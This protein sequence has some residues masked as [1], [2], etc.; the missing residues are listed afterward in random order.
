[1]KKIRELI[2]RKNLLKII[3]ILFMLLFIV[4]IS[5]FQLQNDTFYDIVLGGKYINGDFSKIDTYSIHEGL[6]Y[7]T[8]HFMVCIISFIVYS[9]TSFTGLHVLEIF[10]TCIIATLFYIANRQFVKSKWLSYFWVY[11]EI[12]IMSPFISLRAQM[13]SYILFLLEIIFIEKFLNTSKKKYAIFLTLIPMF[14]A[15]FHSGV[16]YLYYI[17][18]LLYMFNYS[19][20][21]ILRIKSDKRIDFKKLKTF[22]IIIGVSILLSL[23]NPYGIKGLTYG[24]KTINNSFINSYIQEFQPSSINNTL[25]LYVVI[26]IAFILFCVIMSKRDIKLNSILIFVGTTFMFLK[27]L[28]HASI[29]MIFSVMMLSYIE[30]IY[31][32]FKNW[33]YKDIKN[34]DVDIIKKT[35]FL[36]ISM[37]YIVYIST[38]MTYIETDYLNGYPINAVKYI[39]ENIGQDARIYNEYEWGSYLMFNDIKVFI[40]S[41]C[42]LYTEEY[43]KNTRVGMDYMETYDF[44]QDYNDT[45]EKYNIEYFLLK[46]DSLLEKILLLDVKYT[47]I[48]E[49]DTACII[50]VNK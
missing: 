33:L 5:P 48:Y 13:Y 39:K 8:H 50:K 27:S 34:K 41:R 31:N 11:I 35:I 6:V 3:L 40:D 17:I 29:F 25:V 44:K 23:I 30:D 47:K 22:L 15:N 7:Q 19:N 4:V 2:N 37:A 24:L 42:D 36:F 20:I 1:M 21:N 38:R 43:N 28:R 26:Y 49:D 18:I 10:L 9:Y 32:V 46:K 12:I 14:I 16:I 45:V